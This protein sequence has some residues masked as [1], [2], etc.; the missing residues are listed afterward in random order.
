MQKRQC[1][2]KFVRD[3]NKVLTAL[4]ILEEF[5]LSRLDNQD[6][7]HRTQRIKEKSEIKKKL[8]ENL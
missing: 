8:E 3:S 2:F 7:M 6:V 5:T 4:F 1:F